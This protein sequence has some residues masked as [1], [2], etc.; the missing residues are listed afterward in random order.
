MTR[1]GSAQDAA[2]RIP[3]AMP[4]SPQLPGVVVRKRGRSRQQDATG[5][6]EDAEETLALRLLAIRG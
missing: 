5:H 3:P 1:S 2:V 6:E 4:A